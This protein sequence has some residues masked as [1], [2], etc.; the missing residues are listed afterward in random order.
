[1]NVR[2]A[3]L[4]SAWTVTCS[5][6][7]FAQASG[8][9]RENA[10]LEEIVVT[11]Q[12]RAEN[13]QDVP[14][15]ISAI[16]A[17]ALS[18][19][20]V[21][22]TEELQTLAPGLIINM[23]G[24][25]MLPR[26]RG[27]GQTGSTITLENPIAIYVDGVYYGSPSGG[28][29][30]LNNIEQVAVLKGPQ[31]TLFGRNAT[32]G[33]IQVTTR[34]PSSTFGGEAD[35]TMGNHETYGGSLYVTGPLAANVSADLAV[36]Y[37]DQRDGFGKNEFTGHDVDDLEQLT[38]RSKLKVE[39]TDDT[40]IRLAG[41]YARTRAAQPGHRLLDS[42]V[43]TVPN[44]LY[45]PSVGK[46]D[47][48]S[49]VDPDSDIEQWGGSLT[50]A[51]EFDFATLTSISAYRRTT[52]DFT[53]DT[54]GGPA[55]PSATAGQNEKQFSQEFQLVSNTEGPL[56]WTT[57][58]Y[59]FENR[60]FY[61]PPVQVVLPL[62]IAP[63]FP[64]TQ[65]LF[66]ARPKSTSAAGYLQGTYA[67]SDQLN[68]TV[69]GRYTWE[70]REISGTQ[71]VIPAPGVLPITA[72]TTG[73]DD[74]M[75][76]KKPT[77]RL[78]FDYRFTDQAL[79][80]LS[81]N[82]GFKSGGFNPTELTPDNPPPIPSELGTYNAFKAEEI[83]AYETGLKLDL[84]DRRLRINP[85]FYYY[86]YDNLQVVNFT[87]G[88]QKT[89]NAASATIYGADLDATAR[90][91]SQFEM[92][93]GLAWTH[94]RY[95]KFEDSVLWV[96]RTQAEGGG[97]LATIGDAKDNKTA[98]TP[99]W[100]VNVGGTYV[101]PLGSDQLVLNATY[102]HN[103]GWF[104]E[105]ENRIKQKPYDLVNVSAAYRIGESLELSIWG[106]N[107]GNTAYARR[108]FSSESGDLV[109]R[110]PGRTFGATVGVKF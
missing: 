107:I 62:A 13:L 93:L 70:K 38:I 79:A 96:P 15:A 58:L 87:E 82:R 65:V 37:D 9:G 44:P 102:Y 101:I 1:M 80:Y 52:W 69:G 21:T 14:I 4:V 49:N 48:F 92:T 99:D 89:R 19:A 40:T 75:T 88:T 74:E 8:T 31:G 43:P 18:A 3:L 63:G 55:P 108:L 26:I 68:V 32:G 61:D 105:P 64:N 34:D 57:G 83:D 90:I 54:D 97:N 24:G 20:G 100:T 11:A 59:Y 45:P 66:H 35:L 25:Q 7:V 28:I 85:S 98:V 91:T 29:F 73:R 22:N 109:A 72:V 12:K 23:A 5:G 103:D 50:F 71:T 77:W 56:Q 17:Q 30:S 53:F 67:L 36:R 60:G 94:G 76:E 41:D 16:S 84:I 39:L 10:E 78:A 47:V 27:I 2:T 51:H 6:T 106:K 46:F 42:S 86:E 33:L 95:D 81:Y 110:A 104:A